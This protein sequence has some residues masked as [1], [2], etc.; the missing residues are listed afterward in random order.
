MKNV[1]LDRKDTTINISQKLENVILIDTTKKWV[2][3]CPNCNKLIVHVNQHAFK[4]GIRKKSLCKTCSNLV[5]ANPRF[6]GKKH[7]LERNL[8][9]RR[10]ISGK[11]HFMYGK[12]LSNQMKQRLSLK[13]REWRVNNGRVNYNPKACKYFDK[14]NEENGWNLQHALNGGEV[15]II[16]YSLDA[17]DSQLNI[18]IE[19]DEPRHFNLNGR[20]K[21]KDIKRMDEIKNHL[22]CDFYRYNTLSD[23]LISY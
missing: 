4:R 1:E 9:F 7:T 18:V 2:R 21:E 8:K 14:L 11:N 20:L 16:G 10:A 17:Y 12:H 22:K 13:M 19:Y 3:N 5:Y 15:K 23:K 6:T